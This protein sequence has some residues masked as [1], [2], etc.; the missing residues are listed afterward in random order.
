MKKNYQVTHS[1]DNDEKN[2][3]VDIIQSLDRTFRFQEWRREPEDLSGWFLVLDSL[4]S[5]YSSE[6][7][8]IAA[9]KRSII[10]F[11]HMRC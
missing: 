5:T 1:V 4:P 9:A 2:R 8:A 7:E 11:N 6:I 3:C 10:W